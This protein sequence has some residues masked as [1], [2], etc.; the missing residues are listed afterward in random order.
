MQDVSTSRDEAW[1]ALYV[2]TKYEQTVGRL[3]QDKGYAAYVPCVCSE[4]QWADRHKTVQ[5]PLFPNYVFCRFDP[6]ERLP[7]LMTPEV[8]FVVGNGKRPVSIPDE[9]LEAVRR[10]VLYG[11]SVESCPVQNGQHVS[12]VSGP[13]TGLEGVVVRIRNS[14]R[15]VVSIDLLQRAVATEFDRSAVR[16]RGDGR[17]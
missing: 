12:V 17:A 1:F 16:Q 13:L 10:I 3:L 4:R 9:H 6:Y 7:V 11:R 8:Y 5:V 15:L 2:R 14:D